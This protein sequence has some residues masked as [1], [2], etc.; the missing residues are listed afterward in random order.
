MYAWACRV[1]LAIQSFKIPR[2]IPAETKGN[3]M[4]EDKQYSV[5]MPLKHFDHDDTVSPLNLIGD[6]VISYDKDICVPDDQVLLRKGKHITIL[7]E[8]TLARMSFDG[9]R[10][11]SEYIHKTWEDTLDDNWG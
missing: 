9:L 6:W 5:I 3:K 1:L 11:I 4:S 10:Y 7:H 8:D 2:E